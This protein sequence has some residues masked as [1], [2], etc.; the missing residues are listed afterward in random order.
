ML[1]NSLRALARSRGTPEW[2]AVIRSTGVLALLAIYPTIRWP[3]IAG[4]VAFGMIT[5]V[6][7]GP[8]SPL[9]PAS[10]EPVLLLA[11]SMYDPL[12]VAVVATAGTLYMEYINYYLY[13]FAVFHPKLDKARESYWVR[14][15]ADLFEWNPFWAIVIL[16]FT[17]LPY[18]VARVLGPLIR[19]P[20]GKYL[21]ATFVGRFPRLWLYAAFG[22]WL[23]VS[24]SVL[25]A[26][27]LAITVAFLVAALISRRR[28]RATSNIATT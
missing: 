9:F 12:A 4:L 15:S 10:Y 16:A 26:G 5:I 1:P 3:E 20:I 11:G 22:A 18:W 25:L 28:A 24:T 17:P 6:M 23:P 19:Y 13:R 7:N 14:K 27:T 21:W 8:I 2:D